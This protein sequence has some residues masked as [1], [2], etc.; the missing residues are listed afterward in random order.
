M[1]VLSH[2]RLFVAPWTVA[3]QAPLSMKF[4]RQGYWNGQPFPTLGNLPNPRIKLVSLAS[5]ALA[6]RFFTT[7]ATWEAPLYFLALFYN[8]YTFTD[9]LDVVYYSLESE[10]ESEVAQS[11]P[12]LC[13]PVD[14]SLPGSSVHGFL[15]ARILEWIA[16]SFSR[17]SSQPRD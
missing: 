13:N 15:Q 1:C 14:C 3:R 8:F 12:T 9:N 6:G 4:S 2:V 16:I 10:S 7:S 11:C 5:P 17:G